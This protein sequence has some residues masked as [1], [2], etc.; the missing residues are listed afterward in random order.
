MLAIIEALYFDG[1]HV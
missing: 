1:P